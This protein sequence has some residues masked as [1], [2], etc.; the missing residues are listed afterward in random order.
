MDSSRTIVKSR[1]HAQSEKDHEE[2]LDEKDHE[3]DH[4]NDDTDASSE[5][6]KCRSC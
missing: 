6:L 2:S 5:I 4:E 3:N 1:N